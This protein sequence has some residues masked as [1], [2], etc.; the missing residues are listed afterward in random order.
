MP[1][2]PPP[3]AATPP[4][5]QIGACMAGDALLEG[6]AGPVRAGRLKAGDML[7]T[8]GAGLQQI[9][10]VIHQRISAQDMA[11][12]PDLRPVRIRA[13]AL[14]DGLPHRDLLVSRGYRLVVRGGRGTCL[15]AA[16]LGVPGV[17]AA[18]DL[19]GVTY[20]QLCFDRPQILRA[21]GAE[22]QATTQ[23]VGA[24]TLAHAFGV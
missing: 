15:A 1:H 23:P 16:L 13:G 20:V 14:G 8:V 7:R 2:T 3:D 6:Y 22:A 5:R 12:C 4:M 18:D 21:N 19:A 17:A 24:F 10:T 9:R 11:D